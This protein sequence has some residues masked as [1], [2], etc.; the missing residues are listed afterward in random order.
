LCIVAACTV[1]VAFAAMRFTNI[2]LTDSVRY[3]KKNT[4]K[5]GNER[6]FSWRASRLG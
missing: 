5:R 4:E 2:G 6:N 1:G 3:E